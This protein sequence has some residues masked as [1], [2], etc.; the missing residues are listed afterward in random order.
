MA[1]TATHIVQQYGQRYENKGQSINDVFTAFKRNRT[2]PT[3]ATKRFT[4]NDTL[5]LAQADISSVLQPFHK[6]FTAKGDTTIVANEITLRKMKVDI[7]IDPDDIEQ[8]WLGFMADL[9]DGE[10]ANWPIVRYI[11]EVWLA[12]RLAQDHEECDW[13]GIY[14]AHPGSGTPSHLTSYTGLKNLIIAG[15]A[16]STNPMNAV[17]VTGEFSLSGAFEAMESFVDGLPQ[18]WRN[19]AVDIYISQKAYKNYFRDRRNTHGANWGF[20]TPGMKR[21]NMD[22]MTVDGFPNWRL[23]PFGGMDMA[24]DTNW[25]FATPRANIVHGQKTVGKRMSMDKDTRTV[26]LYA[27]WFEAVG[28]LCNAMVYAYDPADSSA[29]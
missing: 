20:D 12:E 8:T 14:T 24:D 18:F 11:W 17:S 16:S 1:I 15:L 28:F 6:T 26:N 10:R 13:N 21:D 4:E 5:Q 9:N 3:F 22:V 25:V 23:V 29:S 19:K 2:L 27:D 7:S